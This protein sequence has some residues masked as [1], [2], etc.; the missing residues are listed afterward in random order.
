MPTNSRYYF[1]ASLPMLKFNAK[2]PLDWD[3]FME[4]AQDGVSAGDYKL[5]EGISKNDFSG[6]GFL[7][8]WKK[9]SDSAD[10]AINDK[11]RANLGLSDTYYPENDFDLSKYVNAVMNAKNPLEAE[12]VILKYKYD[13][14]EAKTVFE[15]FSRDVVLGYALKL[16]LLLRKDL[17]TVEAGNAQ[18]GILFDR[19]KEEISVDKVDIKE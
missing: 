3:T 17:F 11:R 8:D 13:Y 7:R 2:A 1:L 10:R 15:A 4:Y 6:C 18:Y 12:F 19:V 14:L 9:F 5:L 16:E